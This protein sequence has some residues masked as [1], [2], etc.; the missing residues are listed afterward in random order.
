MD[1]VHL[2][3]DDTYLKELREKLKDMHC[4]VAVQAPVEAELHLLPESPKKR[5][6]VPS[7]TLPLA[8]RLKNHADT[9]MVGEK[10]EMVKKQAK[11]II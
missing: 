10:T 7:N 11:L 1:Y 6:A 3:K 5:K 2:L 9:N 4:E 8:K